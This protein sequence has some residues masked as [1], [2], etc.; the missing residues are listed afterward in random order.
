MDEVL[1]QD[2]PQQLQALPGNLAQPQALPVLNGQGQ[3]VPQS[4]AVLVGRQ[5]LF[6]VGDLCQLG[7][8]GDVEARQVADTVDGRHRPQDLG[9]QDV[10]PGDGQLG[11]GAQSHDIHHGGVGG[12]GVFG[13]WDEPRGAGCPLCASC[14]SIRLTLHSG[15]GAFILPRCWR[16]RRSRDWVGT[17]VGRGPRVGSWALTESLRHRPAGA[18]AR[19]C[20]SWLERAS[21]DPAW[22]IWPGTVAGGSGSS[23]AA[24]RA[25]RRGR[26][27]RSMPPVGS[28]PG[29]LPPSVSWHPVPWREPG[30]WCACR[31]PRSRRAPGRR[32]AVARWRPR[33][34]PPPPSL[35]GSPRA[36]PRRGGPR[37]C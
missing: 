2:G 21:S 25:R 30:P 35:P 28:T 36:C 29:G 14:E 33:A 4:P 9:V 13:H 11:D 22:R 5:K 3:R 6:G 17:R 32:R 24:D 34:F 23:T 31:A 10:A 16:Q 27:L 7:H 8:L 18:A 12:R 19:D 1:T 26:A 37:S 20:S 15:G